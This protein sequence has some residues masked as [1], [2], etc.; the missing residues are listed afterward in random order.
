[1]ESKKIEDF[2][3][4]D[5]STAK[6]LVVDDQ[7]INI[8]A[9]YNILSDS[10]TVLAATS[11]PAALEVCN[12]VLPD[13]ILL[14]VLMPG[15]DGLELCDQ[16]KQDDATRDI[17]IIFVTSFNE[18][19]EEDECWSRGGVDFI[20]KPVNP[21]TLKNRVKAHLTLMAQKD[22]L[23]KLVF[24][25]GLTGTF[26][27]RYLDLHLDR[28]KNEARRTKQDAGCLM[29]DIDHFKAFNDNNGHIEGDQALIA[30]ANL[31]RKAL[32]RP[33]DF[34]ARY[35]GEEFAVILPDTDLPGT[36]EVANR[37]ISAFDSEKITN[38]EGT[39]NPITVSIGASTI[40]S[41]GNVEIVECSDT[42]L[43]EAK[44]RGRNQVYHPSLESPDIS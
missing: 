42:Y 17:P 29:V 5:L 38:S 24:V 8:Q 41:C 35:G 40:L 9:V 33:T 14:D 11:G 7:P 3:E 30:T 1:M 34:V 28:V 23:H 18:Q 2:S 37:I 43:Y 16:L 21:M 12:E 22:M 6:I 26:N 39:G 19:H 4:V 31:I 13:L 36:L 20:M 32:L 15:M 44:N 27:R 25:D 10:Y